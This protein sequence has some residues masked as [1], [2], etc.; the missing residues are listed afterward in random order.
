M[1]S[2]F[3]AIAGWYM[4]NEILDQ[5]KIFECIAIFAG[6]V[7]VQIIPTLIKSK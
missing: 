4:I 7:I 5:N 3:A 1:E 6:V 2:V